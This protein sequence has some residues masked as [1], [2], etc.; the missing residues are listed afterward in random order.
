MSWKHIRGDLNC[1]WPGA[2]IAVMG[3][4]GAVEVLYRR[5]IAA[6]KDPDK[7]R[8]ELAEEY[9]KKYCNPYLAAQCGYIDEVF[10]AVETRP[11]L[12]RAFRFLKQKHVDS[13]SKKHGNI[14]L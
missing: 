8:Q 2:Q 6:S 1:A 14:P 7:T 9:R 12:I 4:Q 13:P 3:P 5:E 10:E 11:K